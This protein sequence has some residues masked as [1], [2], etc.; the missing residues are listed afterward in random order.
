VAIKAVTDEDDLMIITTAGIAIRLS[1]KSVRV[2]G[3]NTQGVRLINLREG[4][5]IAA[6]TQVPSD[7]GEEQESAT[8]PEGTEPDTPVDGDVEVKG[9]EGPK[10][11]TDESD[12]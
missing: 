11:A 8:G 7:N 12:S 9:Q 1:V 5:R 4:A 6:A 10:Q 3:R 2:M